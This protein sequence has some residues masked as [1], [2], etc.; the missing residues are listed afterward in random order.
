MG[1]PAGGVANTAQI[2]GHNKYMTTSHAASSQNI[3]AMAR[4]QA[5]QITLVSNSSA[6]DRSKPLKGSNKDGKY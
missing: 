2:S 4:M 3:Q 1:Q 6:V 5:K